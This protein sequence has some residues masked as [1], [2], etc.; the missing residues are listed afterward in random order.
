MRSTVHRGGVSSELVSLPNPCYAKERLVGL[1]VGPVAADLQALVAISERGRVLVSRWDVR[2]DAYSAWSSAVA[3]VSGIVC[4]AVW[5]PDPTRTLLIAATPQGHILCVEL[6]MSSDTSWPW[7]SLGK[8]Q[9]MPEP[10]KCTSIAVTGPADSGTIL[11][12]SS[13]R[14]LTSSI[15][16]TGQQPRIGRL[17]NI[18]VQVEV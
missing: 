17:K 7:R 8:P 15:Q 5:C 12:L 6:G 1:N 9:G 2:A 4:Q 16:I 14:L 3:P 11:V 18:D 10:A 13:G